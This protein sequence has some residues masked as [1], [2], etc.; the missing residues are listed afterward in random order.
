FA[1]FLRKVPVTVCNKRVIESLVKAG[2]F[3]S[4][5][6]SRRGLIHVHAEA[7]DSCMDVKRAEAVGQFDLFSDGGAGDDGPGGLAFDAVIP[8]GEWPKADLLR[9]ERDMLGLYVSDHPLL[10]VEHLL[11][12]LTDT[13]VA[14][15]TAEVVPD[16]QIVTVAG[17]LSTLTRKVT[18]K[19]DPWALAI[20][21]DL[22]GAIEVMFFPATYQQVG[23]RLAED[24]VVVVRGR[25][26]KRDD[27][28]KLIA[29]D[30]SL[31]D[32]SNAPRGPVVV[33]LPA[34]R[35]IPALV[36]R[37]KEVLATH[38]G[39]TEVHLQLLNG[40]RRTAMRLDDGLRVAATQAL[41]ADLKALLGPGAVG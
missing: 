18:K 4:L 21:E 20:L 24:A 38:P 40:E 17:I 29:M 15:L 3:D 26:D 28:P 34:A 2:G 35:C 37:L 36:E 32:V 30:L 7:V 31:P 41:Y 33:S 5:G 11:A 19:G 23:M 6:H 14:A 9:L 10:G 13:S 12:P 8:M 22:E 25:L 39:T 27:V 1:D 16:A